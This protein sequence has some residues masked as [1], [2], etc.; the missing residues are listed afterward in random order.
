MLIYCEAL[1]IIFQKVISKYDSKGMIF[2]L[3]CRMSGH[4]VELMRPFDLTQR[5]LH[6]RGS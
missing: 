3:P 2:V 6:E 5:L 1:R 4:W